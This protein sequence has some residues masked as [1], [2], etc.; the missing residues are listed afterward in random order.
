MTIACINL[1]RAHVDASATNTIAT[2]AIERL[3]STW[4]TI[5]WYT[6]TWACGSGTVPS[7]V[8][9]AK[10]FEQYRD[11]MTDR[12]V[13]LSPFSLPEHSLLRY[14]WDQQMDLF[15][16]IESEE[17]RDLRSYEEHVSL[18]FK[19]IGRWM[20]GDYTYDEAVAERC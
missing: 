5:P 17:T 13:S 2:E 12:G 11:T 8:G 7:R 6:D 3:E 16:I 18:A 19:V 1:G 15:S 14:T 20:T 4:K 10:I 9:N